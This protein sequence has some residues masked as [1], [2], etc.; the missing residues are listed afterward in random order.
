MA[1]P[2]TSKPARWSRAAVAV[3]V[4]LA[5]AGA[6]ALIA[7]SHELDTDAF[8]ELVFAHRAE[9]RSMHVASTG[10]AT[11]SNGDVH[12]T[13]GEIDV[14]QT[15]ES[16]GY[17][18]YEGCPIP[19]GPMSEDIRLC[20]MEWVDWGSVRYER[21]TTSEGVGEWEIVEH[22]QTQTNQP[23]PPRDRAEVPDYWS[24]K[25]GRVELDSE[26][27]DGVE[28][29]RLRA[30]YLLGRRMLERLESGELELP[31]EVPRELLIAD[32]K[33]QVEAETGAIELWARADNGA[34]WKIIT[35]RD[36]LDVNT[37][38]SRGIPAT[39]STYDVM[40]Y[41]RY[42]EPVVIKPPI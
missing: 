42:N 30:S 23:E 5:A 32:L 8:L 21:Q 20:K 34:I 17:I 18:E 16:Q 37:S 38:E 10:M 3:A 7:P 39:R 9:A 29:R 22:L 40:E 25:Y 1:T 35:E 15:G 31:P 12:H 33:E 4:G 6:F 27:V 19:I 11:M 26:T 14:L 28:Y 2:Q 36:N 13:K 41:S 24:R